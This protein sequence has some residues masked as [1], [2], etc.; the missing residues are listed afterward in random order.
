MSY[1]A[2]ISGVV[3]ANQASPTPFASGW[4]V[5][6]TDGT[7]LLGTISHPINVTG[8]VTSTIPSPIT[9][10]G[11]VDISGNPTITSVQGT[12]PWI[13]SGFI[14]QIIQPVAISGTPN[15]YSSTGNSTL[16]SVAAVGTSTTLLNS[17][18]NRKQAI[19]FNDSPSLAYIGFTSSSV[20]SSLYSVQ[21]YSSGYFEMPL[22]CYTGQINGMWAFANGNMRIT[23]IS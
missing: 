9:V 15:V 13:V 21:V 16:T 22:P 11:T 20:T 3:L 14:N 5:E 17:N 7:N 10:N 6:I 4:P 19:F 12:S 18:V 8:T 1:F 23:E 2:S